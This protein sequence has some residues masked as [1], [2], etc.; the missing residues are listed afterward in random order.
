MIKFS[1]NFQQLNDFCQRLTNCWLVHKFKI[2][3]AGISIIMLLISASMVL[4]Q[5]WDQPLLSPLSPLTNFAFIS[6]QTS[7][8]KAS[9][10]KIIYGFLPYWNLKSTRIQPELTHLAYFA[11]KIGPEG[12]LV[13]KSESGNIDPGYEHLDSDQLSKLRQQ[14]E[15]NSGKMEL[16]LIQFDNETIEKIVNSPQAHQNLIKSLDSL[17]LAYPISGINFDIEYAG[18]AD[19]ELRSN[20]TA[21]IKKINEHLDAKY[22]EV[23]LSVDVYAAAVNDNMLWEVDQLADYTDYIIVMAYDFHRRSSTQAG[24]VAPLFAGKKAFSQNIHHHLR[25]FLT[26][27]PKEKLLLGI[28]FYG[29]EWQTDSRLP[30]ANTFPKTGATASYKRVKQIL[31]KQTE[32]EVETGWDNEALCPYLSYLENDYTYMIYYEDQTSLSFKLEYVRQLDLAGIAIWALGY[33]GSHRELWNEID[34]RI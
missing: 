16:V 24:P 20:F 7:L 8:A 34:L 26:H 29:Y 31:D 2:K 25:Q 33:E 11:L 32:L 1:I 6:T 23:K 15:T 18:E 30:K 10:D 12:H 9:N 17:L 5:F 19:P 27:V 28:P 4:W 13:T 22:D 3:L 14:V 21:M